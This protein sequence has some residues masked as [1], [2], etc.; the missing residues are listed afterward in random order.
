MRIFYYTAYCGRCKR[1][2]DAGV[3]EK[4]IT[5]TAREHC[6]YRGHNVVVKEE[7]RKGVNGR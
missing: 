1:I 2:L 4:A 7:K 6:D 3:S 5:A